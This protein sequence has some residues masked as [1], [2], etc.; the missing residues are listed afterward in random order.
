MAM[1]K[2]LQEIVK[3]RSDFSYFTRNYIKVLHPERGLVP[4][5]LHEFQEKKVFPAFE[6]EKFLILRKFR[7][8]G[9]S[10]L[11]AVYSLW[12]ILFFTDVRVLMIS[13]TDRDSKNLMSMIRR[14]WE[15]LPDWMQCETIA[16][17]EHNIKLDTGSEIR[18]GTPK[19]GRGY[20]ANIIVI[21]EAAF[22]P[23]MEEVWKGIFPALS[24][25]GD[26]GK[27]FIISTVN[28]LGNWYADIYH[29]AKDEK[30]DFTYLDLHYTE[31]PEYRKP[32]YVERMKAQL[33]PRGWDQE[34]LGIF[35]SGAD[36]FVRPEVIQK[37]NDRID[38]DVF[39]PKKMKDDKLWIWRP[40]KDKRSYI[41]CADVA[42]GLGGEHDYSAFHVLDLVTLEQ[43]CEFCSNEVSTYEYSK[44]LNEMGNYYNKAIVVV[45]NN[46]LGVGVLERLYND[47]D[48]EN[49]HW[50]RTSKRNVKM[51]FTMTPKNR[52][53]VLNTFSN[54]VE[55]D[56]VKIRSSRVLHEIQTFEYNARTRKAEARPG[57]H[58]DL[59]MAM[60]IGLFTR[61]EII[62]TL[63]VGIGDEFGLDDKEFEPTFD[64]S[65]EEI[66]KMH[67]EDDPTGGMIDQ[68]FSS[69]TEAV[70]VMDDYEDDEDALLKE[71]GW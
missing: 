30:N 10:T 24:A 40:P 53:L 7:Q 23:K 46:A 9:L 61:N 50:S 36:T 56:H 64:P 71:F 41:L 3:C 14:A 54:L 28:G 66:L 6:S 69:Q 55:N 47:L 51:G 33:G 60:A 27:A 35:L 25:A 32:E 70:E 22:I 57:R 26:K 4:F 68:Y 42:E 34:V 38:E 19:M 15:Y 63:P 31:H 44:I 11:A 1:N 16:F 37:L 20:S 62:N 39:E 59:I 65:Y 21:D 52:P 2:E 17:N 48:Y 43:V 13:I 58:D 45:E 49:I 5:D 12:K 67:D 8:A 18:C 29:D